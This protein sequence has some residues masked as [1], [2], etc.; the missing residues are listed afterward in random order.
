MERSLPVVEPRVSVVTALD[1][2]AG[3]TGTVIEAMEKLVEAL[4][5]RHGVQ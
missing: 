2:V 1:V 3:V 5:L 4:A